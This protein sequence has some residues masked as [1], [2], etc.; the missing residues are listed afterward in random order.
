MDMRVT[1]GLV[2]FLA[3]FCACSPKPQHASALQTSVP[4]AAPTASNGL[5]PI[6]VRSHGNANQPV[7]IVEKQGNRRLYELTAKSTESTLQSQSQFRGT[8]AQTHVTFYGATSGATLT[9][10]APITTVDRAKE[11]VLMQGGVKSH[12]SEGVVLTCDQLEYDRSTGRLHGTG[13]VHITSKD[14]Y[15]LTGGSFTSDLRLT[16]VHMQ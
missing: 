8:F 4:S 13:N 10:D 5:P 9:G 12:T 11:S 16:Q 2:L 15:T 14:G 7:R 6:T 3:G 1:L